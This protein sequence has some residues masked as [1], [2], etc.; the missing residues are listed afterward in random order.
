MGVFNRIFA[1]LAVKGGAPDQPTVDATHRK[2]HR[3]ASL[4]KKRAQ[5][6]N[7]SLASPRPLRTV[8]GARRAEQPQGSGDAVRIVTMAAEGSLNLKLH[9]V[10]DEQG[11]RGCRF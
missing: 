11:P 7:D 6:A 5:R 1:G 4:R 8:S 3:T 9:G 10:Y 2:A